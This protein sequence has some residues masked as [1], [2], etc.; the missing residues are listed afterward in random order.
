MDTSNPE[1][2]STAAA[3]DPDEEPTD[4]AKQ[5]ALQHARAYGK[6][7]RRSWITSRDDHI[8]YVLYGSQSITSIML[9]DSMIQRMMTNDGTGDAR[10]LE[11]WPSQKLWPDQGPGGLLEFN[12]RRE[13]QRLPPL[14]RINGM[15]NAGCGGDKIENVIYRLAGDRGNEVKGLADALMTSKRAR[16]VKLWVIHAGTNNLHP[17]RGFTDESVQAFRVLLKTILDISG[18]SVHILVTGLFYRKDIKDEFVDQANA[19]L[20]KI[21]DDL[22]WEDSPDYPGPE[23]QP[24]VEGVAQ[25]ESGNDGNAPKVVDEKGK[26]KALGPEERRDSA[27][28]VPITPAVTSETADIKGKGKEKE[29]IPDIPEAT[30]EED[31][32]GPQPTEWDTTMPHLEPDRGP[33]ISSADPETVEPRSEIPDNKPTTMT[34]KDGSADH[35][36]PR[37]QFSPAPRGEDP[38]MWLV[39]NV[40]LHE[41]GY[42]IWTRDLFP[43][44]KE[45]LSYAEKASP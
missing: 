6:F 30:V 39:D 19:K 5:E 43:K 36:P 32:G 25:P 11:L 26:G 45:M 4:E 20:K 31:T 7:K 41:E 13:A 14:V 1:S 2:S 21:V 29:V 44:V 37:I 38:K 3:R 15:L 40:H 18:K 33:R 23:H 28:G 16:K 42:R 10:S 24:T 35:K 9:G 34:S 12:L 22:V 17:R 8:P 27:I